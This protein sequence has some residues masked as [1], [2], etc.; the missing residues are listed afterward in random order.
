MKHEYICREFGFW[1][2]D[3]GAVGGG[4]GYDDN[5]MVMATHSFFSPLLMIAPLCNG[6][7]RFR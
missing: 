4:H 6:I 3:G 7:L 5:V 1:G 2:S